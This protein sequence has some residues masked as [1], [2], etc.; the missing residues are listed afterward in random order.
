MNWHRL[1][2]CQVLRNQ[3]GNDKLTA[4]GFKEKLGDGFLVRDSDQ[5]ILQELIA[6]EKE[7]IKA[8]TNKN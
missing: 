3:V 4:I 5:D 7:L 2:M 6:L 8:K 1:D